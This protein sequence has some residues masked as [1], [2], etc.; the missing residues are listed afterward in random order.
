[1]AHIHSSPSGDIHITPNLRAIAAQRIRRQED[2]EGCDV[3][4]FTRRR[5]GEILVH[6]NWRKC[7]GFTMKNGG[8][9]MV[10]HEK[11]VILP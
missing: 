1:M 10:Y 3:G 6:E 8:L 7:S 11:W 4:H 9:T 2:T 5:P